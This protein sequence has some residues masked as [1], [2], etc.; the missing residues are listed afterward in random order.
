MRSEKAR[1]DFARLG[2]VKNN[3]VTVTHRDVLANGFILNNEEEGTT[4][5]GEGSIDAVFLDLPRP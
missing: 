3:L 2:F 1:E 4:Q 5:V